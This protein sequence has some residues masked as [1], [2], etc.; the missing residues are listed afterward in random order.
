MPITTEIKVTYM[1]RKLSRLVQDKLN[2]LRFGINYS[3]VVLQWFLQ[4]KKK[5]KILKTW[6]SNMIKSMAQ[7]EQ[8]LKP[9][10]TVLSAQNK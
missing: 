8:L 7:I 6:R 1:V 9:N 5:K 4:K 2:R 3:A 10:S